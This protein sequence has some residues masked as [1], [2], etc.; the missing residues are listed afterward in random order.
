MHRP[1]GADEDARK[2][3]AKEKDRA[4]KARAKAR[5]KEAA[6]KD[7]QLVSDSAAAHALREQELAAALQHARDNAAACAFCAK[8]MH[9]VRKPFNMPGGVGTCCSAD[10][11]LKARKRLQAAAAEARLSAQKK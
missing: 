8:N 2:E 6:Q 9:G 11:A 7:K 10:C 4:R 3:S 1:A 5:K